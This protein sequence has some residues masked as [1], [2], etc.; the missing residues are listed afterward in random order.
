MPTLTRDER[1]AEIEA[2]QRWIGEQ[3]A[4][5]ESEAFPA[6]VAEQWETNN[7]RLDDLVAEEEELGRRD[8]RLRQLRERDQN[9]ERGTYMPSPP[10][11][12][13]SVSSG[14]VSISRMSESQVYDLSG[15]RFNPFVEDG[16]G[17]RELRERAKR[18]A[19]IASYP[20]LYNRDAAIA[21]VHRL[22]GREDQDIMGS[23]VA[24]RILTTGHPAYRRAF[25]KVVET[26]MRGQVVVNLNSEEQRAYDAVRA[27]ATLTP[28]GGGYAVPYTLDPTVIPTSNL[29]VNP[30]RAIARVEQITGNQWLGVTSAGVTA[31]YAAEA[32]EASDNSPTL[33]QPSATVQRAHVFVPASIEITQ[34]WGALQSELA[35]LIQDAKDDLEAAQ[36]TTGVGTTVFPQ[37]VLVGAT[38]T[39]A[40]GGVASFAVG[41]L[42]TLEAALPPRFRPR[43]QFVAARSMYGKIRQFDTAGGAALWTPLP[44]PLAVGLA[45]QVPTPGGIGQL[46]LGYSAHECSQ[47]PVVLTTG[48]K[49]VAFGDWRYYIIVDRIGM[50]IEVIPHLFGPSQRPTGQRGFYAF[51]RNT[52]KVIDPNGF[53]ILVTG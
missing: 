3:H 45:N 24:R 18:A 2:L 49:I 14:V 13:S 15:I 53:R 30:Y 34:D 48:S 51:W 19:E 12:T 39:Q 32:A 50:D 28:G 43:A 42:Y 8:R 25:T 35:S 9:V 21:H 6:D 36:F 1:R 11:Q 7:R 23:L 44:A 33:A 5:F 52:A 29:S 27:M 31:S 4:E 22:L 38:S 40:A 37:G 17:A 47:M 26:L 46:L 41:D 20:D 10:S 16:S